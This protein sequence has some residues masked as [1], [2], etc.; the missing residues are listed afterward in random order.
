MKD[1]FSNFFSSSGVT[2]KGA[3]DFFNDKVRG[4]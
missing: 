2:L 4:K 1:F 3:A